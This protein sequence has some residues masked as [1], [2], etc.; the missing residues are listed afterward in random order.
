[1]IKIVKFKSLLTLVNKDGWII[2]PSSGKIVS[3]KNDQYGGMEEDVAELALGRELQLIDDTHPR[4]VTVKTDSGF[5]YHVPRSAI[6]WVKEI[7]GE[8]TNDMMGEQDSED[9]N[10]LI[11]HSF[12]NRLSN[13]GVQ[14]GGSSW[15]RVLPDD[16]QE[17]AISRSNEGDDPCEACDHA[18]QH[19]C[20]FR[21]CGE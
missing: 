9:L 18:C 8:S 20:E 13:A 7:V 3:D 1:M 19:T 11:T 21:D 17:Q 10:E 12:Y 2:H 16:W 15:I 6:E 4:R 14:V 5:N